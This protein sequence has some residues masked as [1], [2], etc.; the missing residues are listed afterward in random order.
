MDWFGEECPENPPNGHHLSQAE[1]IELPGW[2]ISQN[3]KVS[4][5]PEGYF[6]T[7]QEGI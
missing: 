3:A 1:I 5:T 6:H 2:D 4:A 7:I